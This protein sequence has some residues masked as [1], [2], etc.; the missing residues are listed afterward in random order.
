MNK[1]NGFRSTI[2]SPRNEILDGKLAVGLVAGFCLCLIFFVSLGFSGRGYDILQSP[3]HLL[4][5]GTLG[6]SF[7]SLL[8]ALKTF[9]EQRILRQAGTDPVLIA[10]LGER[11][12]EPQVVQ[13]RVSNVGAGAAQDVKIIAQKP[14][15]SDGKLLYAKLFEEDVFKGRRRIAA[16]LQGQSVK[17]SLGLGL[18]LFDD[19]PLDAFKVVLEYKDIE[20]VVY[21][22]TH[23]IDVRELSGLPADAPSRTKTWRE[24]EKIRGT[25]EKK[26]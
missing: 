10:H 6:V 12:D 4:S 1:H 20:G 18:Q 19:E 3:E 7:T 23:V 8:I 14:E 9:N 16:I 5:F 15:N 17:Y 2:F 26:L 25:L 11:E 22:S 21:E 24:L 13:L